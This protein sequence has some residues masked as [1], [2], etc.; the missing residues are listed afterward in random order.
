LAAKKSEKGNRSHPVFPYC[1]FVIF[2]EFA[3]C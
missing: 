1:S 3:R 2:G